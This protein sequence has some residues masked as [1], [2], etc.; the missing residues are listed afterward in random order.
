MFKV[1]NKD[2]RWMD[3]KNGLHM[4]TESIHE[5]DFSL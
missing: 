1:N 4:P 5:K 3:Y 2:T